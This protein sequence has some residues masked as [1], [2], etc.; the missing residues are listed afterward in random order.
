M[1][2]TRRDGVDGSFDA[3][4][5]GLEVGEDGCVGVRG[6]VVGQWCGC[7]DVVIVVRNGD[8]FGTSLTSLLTVCNLSIRGCA[9]KG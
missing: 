8:P 3:V 7:P 4:S 1:G 6:N 5:V 2:E 9:C